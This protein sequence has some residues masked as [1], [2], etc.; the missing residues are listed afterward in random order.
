MN[1]FRKTTIAVQTRGTLVN[2]HGRMVEGTR[3]SPFNIK[4]SVQPLSA[5]QMQ[6]LP[7]GRRNR[8]S[9]YVFSDTDLGLVSETN[10]P[11]LTISGVDY[12]LVSKEPWLNGIINHFKYLASKI[13][14]S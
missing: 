12:E 3:P 10:P 1:S 8:Q 5:F 11:I 13:L 6:S 14:E 9:L 7:E 4:A 2:D